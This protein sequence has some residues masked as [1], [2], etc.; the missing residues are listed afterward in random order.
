MIWPATFCRF[1]AASRRCGRRPNDPDKLD[2]EFQYD[3]LYRFDLRLRDGCNAWRRRIPY[4]VDMPRCQD[5]TSTRGSQRRAASMTR[6]G[7]WPRAE[8]TTLR[9]GGSF[10]RPGSPWPPGA[11]AWTR[12]AWE[13]GAYDYQYDRQWQ[14]DCGKRS[15][16]V[17]RGSHARSVIR[18]KFQ[19]TAGGRPSKKLARYLH[20]SAGMRVKKWVR[21]N[22]AAA[23]DQG[24]HLC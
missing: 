12:Y 24:H 23:N 19:E 14:H 21:T 16:D 10:T 20:D 22:G 13:P 6:P 11:I 9:H 2:R 15:P 8:L 7:T 4:W 5:V 1:M 18:S 17:S 3:A